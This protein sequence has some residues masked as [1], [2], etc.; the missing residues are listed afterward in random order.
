MF[1]L[2]AND[3]GA[4]SD[5]VDAADKTIQALRDMGVVA[6]WHELDCAITLEAARGAALARG[7][8]KAQMLTALL[9]ARAKLPAPLASA[10]DDEFAIVRSERVIE[11]RRRHSADLSDEAIA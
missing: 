11:W 2:E 6:P 10:D 3:Y 7:V 5:L 1:A 4:P 9:A 8:A